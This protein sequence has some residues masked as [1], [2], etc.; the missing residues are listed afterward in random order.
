M[1]KFDNLFDNSR[2]PGILSIAKTLSKEEC[3]QIYHYMKEYMPN[4]IL[5]FGV[6]FG[7]STAVFLQIAEWLGLDIELHSWDIIDV[8]KKQCVD[9][10]DFNFHKVDITGR[11]EE[12]ILEYKPDMVFLDAHPYHMTKDLMINCV[13]YKINFLTHD[14]AIGLYNE[15][16]IRSD[17]FNKLEIYGA[18]ELYILCELFSDKLLIED[19]FENDQVQIKCYR[20]QWGLSV[21]KVK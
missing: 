8:V 7:C 13:K 10:N 1:E 20:D 11:E 4:K 21:I 17:N 6:Q 18:W 3:R 12:I 15:L 2:L 19:Y 5:E 16:K 14:V 9:K